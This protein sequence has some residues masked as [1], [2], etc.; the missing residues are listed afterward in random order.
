MAEK[1]TKFTLAGRDLLALAITRRNLAAHGAADHLVESC[2]TPWLS[3]IH[4]QHR[5][6]II[7][8]GPDS[9]PDAVEM[10]SLEL[11][12]LTEPDGEVV[13]AAKSALL[14]R[15]LKQ[16]K[17]FQLKKRKKNHGYR[18]VLLVKKGKI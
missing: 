13:I 12:R 10:I 8:P 17:G 14:Q 5:R 7:F 3:E 18:A 2:H 6:V 15:I 1:R 4:D 11:P 9:R 16:S